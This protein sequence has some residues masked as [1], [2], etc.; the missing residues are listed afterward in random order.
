MTKLSDSQ[1]IV[2]SAAA[3]RE[4]GVAIVPA[5]MNK[6]R[7]GPAATEGAVCREVEPPSILP[8]A[9]DRQDF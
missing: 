4:D 2:L 6:V 5:K 8:C 9:A 7:G 1:L 3:A